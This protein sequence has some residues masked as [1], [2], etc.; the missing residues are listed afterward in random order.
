V[1]E[2][3]ASKCIELMGGVGFT[4]AYGVEKLYRDAKIGASTEIEI[5]IEIES[6]I[7]TPRLAPVRRLTLRILLRLRL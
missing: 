7:V 1:A 2:K 5:E 6:E 4:R 3:T